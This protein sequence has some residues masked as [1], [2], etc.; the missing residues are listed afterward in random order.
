MPYSS[1][2][3]PFTRA[4]VEPQAFRLDRLLQLGAGEYGRKE[5]RTGHGAEGAG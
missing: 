2:R 4:S 3:R 1:T 5:K